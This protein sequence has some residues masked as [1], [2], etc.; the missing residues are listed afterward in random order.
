LYWLP[1]EN[2]NKK[3][4]TMALRLGN[5]TLW[6][7][8]V[9]LAF[10]SFVIN[11]RLERRVRGQQRRS[12]GLPA[13][14]HHSSFS[15]LS[16]TNQQSLS[17]SVMEME[18]EDTDSTTTTMVY[19]DASIVVQLSGEM[20]NNL[21]KLAFGRGLQLLLAEQNVTTNLVL[22]HQEHP[23]WKLAQRNIQQCF[24]NLAHFDF[25]AGNT[26]EFRERQL[27]Q[28]LLYG[29]SSSDLVLSGNSNSNSNAT[30]AVLDHLNHLVQRKHHS[31]PT[32]SQKNNN[33]YNN[34][35]RDLWVEPGA[36]IQ[37]PF[38]YADQMVSMEFMDRFKD[39]FLEF[40]RFDTHK[41]CA[42]LP[43]DD[44]SVFVRI[45]FYWI[46][47]FCVVCKLSLTMNDCTVYM[48][49]TPSI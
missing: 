37:P 44:E 9:L 20:G 41:C 47:F 1:N 18:M 32:T 7:G 22:R 28:R 3:E 40:F 12:R 30:M 29:T 2:E 17:S 34:N 35:T 26:P 39:D 27:Q 13:H 15:Y 6:G 14:H 10:C 46:I 45:L 25:Q 24:P 21:N 31:N 49:G 4:T 5:G 23:K 43:D 11:H 19:Y 36:T 38:L 16:T 8:L 48:C 33:I 42:T